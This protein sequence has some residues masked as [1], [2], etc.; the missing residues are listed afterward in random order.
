MSCMNI[1][2]RHIAD[3]AF[4]YQIDYKMRSRDVFVTL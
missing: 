2:E 3:Q 1:H 4:S